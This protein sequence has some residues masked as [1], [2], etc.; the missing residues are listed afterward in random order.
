MATSPAAP[1]APS[2]DRPTAG[3]AASTALARTNSDERG[4]TR[5]VVVKRETRLDRKGTVRV[6]ETETR[7]EWI[8]PNANQT[9]HVEPSARQAADT[10]EDDS[11]SRPNNQPVSDA[12]TN[13]SCGSQS[14]EQDVLPSVTLLNVHT[15][16]AAVR[17]LLHQHQMQ[18]VASQHEQQVLLA[19][20]MH[21]R[22]K[23]AGMQ[24]TQLQSSGVQQ[25]LEENISKLQEG[26]LPADDS[27]ALDF[28][29]QVSDLEMLVQAQAA[30][31][32]DSQRQVMELTDVI[33][34]V[35]EQVTK[36]VQSSKER[37][38]SN[39]SKVRDMEALLERRLSAEEESA[40]ARK[41]RLAR[42]I[43]LEAQLEE[44]ESLERL[45]QDGDDE[46]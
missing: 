40:R 43:E 35:H 7:T 44:L 41:A 26:A 42:I 38:E 23:L 29:Q 22:A 12:E 1:Q 9:P 33:N 32:Q 20:Q 6:I 24:Q 25:L 28:A 34:G 8:E 13:D 46:A 18:T 39:S 17:Q 16:L 15:D 10:G 2:P 45:E 37:L 21:V 19:K 31:L 14:D 5:Q 3:A 11:A 27:T 4:I 36:V 30:N